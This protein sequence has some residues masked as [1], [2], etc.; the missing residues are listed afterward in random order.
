M[1]VGL[2]Y[3]SGGYEP[4]ELLPIPIAIGTSGLHPA[5]YFKNYAFQNSAFRKNPD[6][7]CKC[8]LLFSNLK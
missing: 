3:A 5:I 2:I 8:T 1:F 4:N 6:C 7:G